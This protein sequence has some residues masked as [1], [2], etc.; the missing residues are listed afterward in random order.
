MGVVLGCGIKYRSTSFFSGGNIEVFSKEGIPLFTQ[1][2][3]KNESEGTV[4]TGEKR[5]RGD[6]VLRVSVEAAV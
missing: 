1:C 3:L 4:Q 6:K 5:C 2:P